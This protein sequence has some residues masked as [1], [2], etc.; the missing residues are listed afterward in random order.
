MLVYT[1]VRKHEEHIITHCA[2]GHTNRTHLP[3]KLT[4]LANTFHSY[5][6][7]TVCTWNA[8][9]SITSLPAN[10]S[11]SRRNKRLKCIITEAN[12]ILENTHTY[13]IRHINKYSGIAAKDCFALNHDLRWSRKETPETYFPTFHW[14][15]VKDFLKSPIIRLRFAIKPL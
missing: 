14:E 9:M 11:F 1:Y 12:W 3:L 2:V 13:A 5:V 8:N 10:M 4:I 7:S 15:L 6:S